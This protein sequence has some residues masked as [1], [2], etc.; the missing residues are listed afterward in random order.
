VVLFRHVL[1]NALI[2]IITSA[3]GYLPYVFLGSL[4]F[5]S[6][7]GIPGLGAY[8]IEAIGK[9]DFA[10]VR[11]M[12]FVGSAALHRHLHPDRHRL[13]VGGPACAWPDLTHELGVSVMPKFVSCGPTWPCG[14]CRRQWSPTGGRVAQANL[15][16]TGARCSATRR[17]GSSLVLWPAWCDAADSVHYRRAAATGGRAGQRQGGLRHPH[18]SLLDAGAARTV[19]QSRESTYSAPAG[20]PV[21]FTKESQRG[22]G[23]SNGAPPAAVRRRPPDRPGQ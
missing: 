2:P 22:G 3:G 19:V 13:H 17:P 15:V 4:V 1:R 11:T 6:F 12:V 7:F 18:R 9:Q 14:C 5:E 16:P 21:S 8:V 10:I 23:P 20:L